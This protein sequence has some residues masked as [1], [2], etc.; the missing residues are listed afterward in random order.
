MSFHVFSQRN[1]L[2]GRTYTTYLLT[3]G[4]GGSEAEV[5]PELGGNCLRWRVNTHLGPVELL[6]VTPDW[7][8]TPAPNRSGIPVLFPFPNRIRYGTFTWA[9]REFHLPRNDPS[10]RHAIHG[11]ACRQ[12]WR[13]R[14]FS[15]AEGLATLTLEFRMSVDVPN[16]LELWPEDVWLTLRYLLTRDSLALAA[17]IANPGSEPV[18]VGLGYHPFFRVPFSRSGSR[19]DCRVHVAAT[20]RWE[21]ID[22]IPTGR[23]VPVDGEWDLTTP[24]AVSEL[25]LDDVYTGFVSTDNER[26]MHCRGWIGEQGLG[27]VELWTSSRFRDV[28][29]FTPEHGHAICLEP[30]TCVTD[31]INLQAQGVDT[32]MI[33]LP[34]GQNITEFVVFR[35]VAERE[36]RERV[37]VWDTLADSAEA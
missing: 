22:Q 32:G 7:L 31:A 36:D 25:K 30:Y 37:Q 28:V 34:P 21:L 26:S 35:F 13:V 3:E 11:F 16:S 27:R 33:V 18:P 12:P 19:K 8:V 6:Y 9:G 4:E 23:C 2:Q 15:Q 24:R 10:R 17:T 5:W 20:A 29:V 14:N 1:T